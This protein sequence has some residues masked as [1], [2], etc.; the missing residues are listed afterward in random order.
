M[1]NN[2]HI[3]IFLTAEFYIRT[4]YITGVIILVSSNAAVSGRT[5][6]P[7]GLLQVVFVITIVNTHLA[8][9]NFEADR[10]NLYLTHLQNKYV[11]KKILKL[12]NRFHLDNCI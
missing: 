9:I 2:L 12:D 10:S 5:M 8:M 1:L 11:Q 3:N 6:F 7:A 4:Y